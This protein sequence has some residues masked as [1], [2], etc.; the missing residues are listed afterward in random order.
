MVKKVAQVVLVGVLLLGMGACAS[1]SGDDSGA[2][3]SERTAGQASGTPAGGQSAETSATAEADVTAL[4]R[5]VHDASWVTR[6]GERALVV[7]PS[8]LLRDSSSSDVFDEAWRRIV[9]AVPAADTPGMRDQFICHA[10][11]AST[12]D[13]WYLEPA[14]PAVG[15]WRTVAAGCNPGDVRDVG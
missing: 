2:P 10:S 12:K 7:T 5:L 8:Q 9:R 13:A 11:F 3:P 6:D 15:Y 1:A 14:R 4:P